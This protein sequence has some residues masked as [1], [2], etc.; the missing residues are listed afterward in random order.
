MLPFTKDLI[1]CFSQFD[2]L[3]LFICA[4]ATADFRL[5]CSK[6]TN[7]RYLPRP[8]G[9]LHSCAA[10]WNYCINHALVHG[11]TAMIIAN[12]DLI[13]RPQIL[14]EFLMLLE[15]RRPLIASPA[16]TDLLLTRD[17]YPSSWTMTFRERWALASQSL[18]RRG[19]TVMLNDLYAPWSG[20]DKFIQLLHT[21]FRGRIF[22]DFM[23]G[24]IFYLTAE[25]VERIG[26]FDLRFKPC[27]Y[28]DNDFR[29]RAQREL[30]GRFETYLW[31]YV[32]HFIGWTRRHHIP[33]IH[34]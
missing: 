6:N 11:Y 19:P 12:D 26:L 5:E 4:P 30:A 17:V 14:N 2:A 33:P 23:C 32:H 3:D 31:L 25:A 1:N 8:Q 21:E 15:E 20:L 24:Q 27:G 13:L 10:I 9:I 29:S 16:P 18:L 28:E 22:A 34:L 7:L